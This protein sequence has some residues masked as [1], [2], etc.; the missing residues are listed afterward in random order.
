MQE[1]GELFVQTDLGR[2]FKRYYRGGSACRTDVVALKGTYNLKPLHPRRREVR[3]AVGLEQAPNP[4]REE[5]W[6]HQSLLHVLLGEAEK[7]RGQDASR[8]Q[9]GGPGDSTLGSLKNLQNSR[10]HLTLSFH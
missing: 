10:V 8:Q 4:Q 7:P 6:P 5:I 3:S 2:Q 9:S 1:A